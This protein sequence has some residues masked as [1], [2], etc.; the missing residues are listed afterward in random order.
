MLKRLSHVCLGVADIDASV[1][2]YG[3]VLGAETAH[4][5]RNDAGERYGVMLA[6]GGGTFIE[7]FRRRAPG[8]CATGEPDGGF[9]HLCFEVADI[10]A[11]AERLSPFLKE[12]TIRRGRTDRILQF[13]V[14]DPD[15]NTVEFHQHDE[16][17]VLTP[18]LPEATG[19]EKER[20]KKEDR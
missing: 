10:A 2:F 5:F 11:A 7:L 3:D 12:T 18:W 6:C 19:A 16:E 8:A 13:F 1:A 15:G 20:N 14:H 4:E 17:S 9:R